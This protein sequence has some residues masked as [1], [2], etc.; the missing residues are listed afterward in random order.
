MTDNRTYIRLIFEKIFKNNIIFKFG[1]IFV[2][3]YY[4][5]FSHPINILKFDKNLP[6]KKKDVVKEHRFGIVNSKSSILD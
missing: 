5:I 1:D 6:L 2:K 4:A 3:F